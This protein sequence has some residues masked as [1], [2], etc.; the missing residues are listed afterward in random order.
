GGATSEAMTDKIV[1]MMVGR[2]IEDLYPRSSRTP[3][4]I[5]LDIHNLTGMQ[6]PRSA[7]LQLHRGE[8]LG[9]A[10][11][12][13]AGRTELLRAI[14]GLD[15]IKSGDVRIAVH[16]G[17]ASPSARWDQQVG[18]VS[19]DRKSEGLALELSLADNLTLSKLPPLVLPA[20]QNASAQNWIT[21][22]GIRA[23]NASQKIRDLSGGNQQK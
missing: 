6:K 12:V 20:D 18:M 11:L 22:L 17:R 7:S 1:S 2:K 16:Q 23:G 14:F 8:V 9:I 13:G 15:R 10:G 4:E 21:R 19:E 5:V 3:G